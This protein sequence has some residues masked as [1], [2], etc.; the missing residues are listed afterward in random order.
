MNTLSSLLNWIGQTIGANPNT[1][2]TASKTI[3][4]AINE[5]KANALTNASTT[6]TG[7]A[8]KLA[9][10]T[11][12][13]SLKVKK[14]EIDSNE[15]KDSVIAQGVSGDWMYRKWSSGFLEQWGKI[16]V[17]ANSGAGTATFP[18]AFKDTA[19]MV[20]ATGGYKSGQPAY[21]ESVQIASASTANVYIRNAAGT[22]PSIQT[23]VDIYAAGYWK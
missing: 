8:G 19:F 16:T 21:A 23:T 11:S 15:V 22:T 4:G 2:T 10:I 3:V 13:Q 18:Q 7:E 20:F 6:E 9:K 14:I 17:N 1:L 5:V 12:E